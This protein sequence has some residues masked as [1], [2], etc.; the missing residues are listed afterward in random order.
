VK[1]VFTNT[2][3]VD[4]YR[5]AG[6]PE[7]SFVIERLMDEA[8]HRLGLPPQEIRQ[9]NFLRR[10]DYP[11]T[12]ALGL[13][14]DCGDHPALLEQALSKSDWSGFSERQR[15]SL[16]GGKY[17]GIGLSAY[18]EIA[19]GSPSHMISAQGGRGGSYESARVQVIPSGGVI[20]SVGTH[21]HGQSH[22]TVFPRLV[23]ERL[24]LDPR[25][26]Q[27]VQGDTDRVPVGRGTFASRSLAIAGSAIVTGLDRI[28]EKMRVIAGELME[29]RAADIVFEDGRLAVR[30]TDRSLAFADVARAAYR[31]PKSLSGRIAPGLDETAFVE[32][33]DWT[34]PGGCHVV[35]V[36]VDPETGVVQ[37]MSVTAIDDVGNVIDPIIVEGQIHGGLAQGL[38]QAMMEEVIHDMGSNQPLTGSFM[39]YALPRAS[40]LISFAS[41]TCAVPTLRNPLGVKGCAESGTVGVPA[42]FINAVINA[43]RPLGVTDLAMPATPF[44]VW[45]AINLARSRKI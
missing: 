30:G 35:E 20:V 5:G 15:H 10:E 34:F 44:R 11:T 7:A 22:E 29:V 17:R 26:V 39:D 24:G 31:L 36:E 27:F 23:A 25:H 19:G 32:P 40:N 45:S 1:L 4:A 43:L 38:G 41:G 12:T 13:S 28:M 33:P 21:S 3:P 16:S 37:L 42:A 9:R 6:R 14:I 18:L 8:A 2:T